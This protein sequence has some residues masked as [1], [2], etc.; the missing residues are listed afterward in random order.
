MAH[1]M[2]VDDEPGICWA[3]QQFLSDH[4]HRVSVAATAEQALTLA[5]VDPPEV[6]FLDIRLPGEDGLSALGR[7]RGCCPGAAIVVM[8]A[9]GTVET[10]V[11]S[12]RAGALDYLPKPFDLSQ[13]LSLVDRALLATAA[14]QG[15]VRQPGSQPKPGGSVLLVGQSPALQRVFKQIAVTAACDAPVVIT[16]ESGTGKELVARAIHQHGVRSAQPFVP[17][18]LAALPESLIERELFGHERGAFTGADHSQPGLLERAGEGTLFLDEI[19]EATPAVQSKLLRVLDAG[20]YRRVGGGIERRLEAR[21]LAANNRDIL[22]QVHA[23]GF[24][25][26]LYYRLAVLQIAVPPL[27]E[28]PEDVIALWDYWLNRISPGRHA[29][30]NPGCALAAVLLGYTWP[31][32]VRELKNTVEH[33]AR[34][35]GG[36]L[37]GPEHLPSCV[38]AS[39]PS[40]SVSPIAATSSM[41]TLQANV[42]AWAREQLAAS[43]PTELETGSLHDQLLDVVEAPL[44]QATREWAEGNQVRMARRLGLHRTTLR[45]KLRKRDAEE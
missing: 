24:R 41:E 28:R 43:S 35:C 10:A 1:V 5:A 8:T 18:H 38:L 19:T 11:Q 44:L 26:D 39:S 36:G 9:Y 23:G 17:I 3:F 45:E 29:P 15:P 16:G 14:G 40:T 31:G 6:V 21:V 2:V 34:M 42:F 12:V 4:G 22:A 20:D 32:N 25:A 33:A 37:I 27:R 7:I 30:L 13:I